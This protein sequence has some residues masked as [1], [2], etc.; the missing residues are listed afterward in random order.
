MENNIETLRGHLF[1]TLRALNDK[2]KPMDIERAKAVAEV[3][4]VI[5]NSA[6]AEVEHLKVVGGKSTGFIS[7]PGTIQHK[8]G[9]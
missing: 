3:A 5:I 7:P 6:K 2:E 1:D 9:G 8:L 4:Q